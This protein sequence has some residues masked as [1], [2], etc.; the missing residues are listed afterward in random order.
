MKYDLVIDASV[1][2]CWCFPDKRSTYADKILGELG[3]KQAIV[4]SLWAI[5]LA[6]SLLVGERRK[7]LTA[8][9]IANFL[10]ILKDLPVDTDDES[11]PRAL[12]DTWSL[13]RRL[14]LSAYDGCYLELAMREGLPLATLDVQMKKAAKAAGVK[15]AA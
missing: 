1:A 5:E 8:A 13:A 4:P 12:S 14:G 3:E 15:I 11:A 9:D 2:L 10:D 6:N 7:R